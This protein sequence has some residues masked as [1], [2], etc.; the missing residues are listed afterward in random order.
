M[1]FNTPD[2]IDLGVDLDEVVFKY[3]KGLREY[4]GRNGAPLPLIDPEHFSLTRSGWFTS[5]EEFKRIHG[6]AVAEGL[7]ANLKLYEEAAE[8]LRDLSRSGYRINIITSRFVNPGQHE[9]V[10]RDTA[11]ALEENDIPYSNLSFLSN[12]TKM[13]MDAYIDDG[14]HNL[15]PLI[16]LGR[17]TITFDQ[18]YNQFVWGPRANNWREVREILRQKFGR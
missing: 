2:L 5:D 17:F 8:V 18:T 6:E 4:T 9:I 11:R 1:A 16:D 3:L 12:K 14:P 13:L 15:E 10:V 7:Y